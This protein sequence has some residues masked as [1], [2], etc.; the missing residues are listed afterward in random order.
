MKVRQF[1]LFGVVVV[2]SCGGGGSAGPLATTT[3]LGPPLAP[4]T[5]SSD[6]IET[7]LAPTTTIDVEAAAAAAWPAVFASLPQPAVQSEIGSVRD[8]PLVVTT[9]APS[10]VIDFWSFT[11]GEWVV[12]HAI[13][14]DWNEM[15]ADIA[16]EVV[17]TDANGDAS[18]EALV[19]YVGGMDLWGD[20]YWRG[21]SGWQLAT[22]GKGLDLSNGTLG[23]VIET[24]IPNCAE[25]P[26]IPFEVQWNGTGWVNQ[27]VDDFGNPILVFDDTG[28]GGQYSHV[29]YEP[30]G[31]CTEGD[32][33]YMLQYAL[34][35]AGFG[36][37]SDTEP[38]MADGYFGPDTS[39]AVRIYQ[40][41]MGLP[42]TGVVE[43]QWYHDLIE[44]YGF[45]PDY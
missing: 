34:I 13:A 21:P 19:M 6:D 35:S 25:G 5:T 44:L 10:G 42:V 12:S 40:Y 36:Y 24:C 14:F 30:F 4:S 23:G 22:S 16:P 45:V 27:T 20:L 3:T 26:N 33:V 37:S 2:A 11:D 15:F 29:D 28:C 7:T 41:F 32:A 1:W 18:D 17:L 38:P 43:G 8:T 39:T 9:D 31:K